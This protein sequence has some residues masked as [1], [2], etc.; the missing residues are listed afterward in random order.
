METLPEILKRSK[1]IVIVKPNSKKTK[2]ASVDE[3]REA[4][5][6][7]LRAP[8]HEG[9]ANRELISFLHKLTRKQVRIVRG[10]KSKEKAVELL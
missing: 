10:L 8:A 7:E 2:I 5:K 3:D 1:I 4:L 9:K 6:I